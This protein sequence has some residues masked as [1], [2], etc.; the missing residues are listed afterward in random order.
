MSTRYKL[1]KDTMP[2]FLMA[3]VIK[4]VLILIAFLVQSNLLD[5]F[6]TRSPA[7][8]TLIDFAPEI[9]LSL[10]AF[11][12]GTLIIV[13]SIASEKTPKL[14]DLFVTEYWSRLFIWLIA[15]SSM[16]NIFLHLVHGRNTI[17]IDNFIFLNNYILLPSFVI[18]AIPYIFYILKFTKSSNVIK[19]IYHENIRA[20][21]QAAENLPEV[22]V[23]RNH[24]QLLET[25]NQLNDL[26]QY[27]EFKGPKGDIITRL[28]KSLRFYLDH[29]KRIPSSYFK[30]SD[31]I[32]NDISFRTLGE[33][34]LQIENERT[35]YEHKILRVLGTSYLLLIKESHYDL[36]SLCGNEL[37][38]S[39]RNAA[40]LDDQEVVN[41]IIIHFNTIL[42]FGINHGIKAR[43]IRNVYNTIFHY[44]QLIH[45]FIKKR[46]EERVVQC[47]RYFGFY[48]NEVG[49]LSL[50]EP[51]FLF[52]I[53]IFAIEM[54]KILMSL[55]INGLSREHQAIVLR[56][57]NDLSSEKRKRSFESQ[58]LLDS[59][60]RLIQIALCL[61]YMNQKEEKFL[62]ITVGAIIKDFGHLNEKQIIQILIQDLTGLKMNVRIFGRKPIREIG[63][64]TTH[65]TKF[66]Y[67]Y[68]VSMYL[69]K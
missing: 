21:S 49:K 3:I 50:S 4:V 7:D 16:E 65:H 23:N 60:L 52:L 42:R 64:F 35:F 22:E 39:A 47:C 29:K 48:A 8:Y 56:M 9:W 25:I 34:Y 15:L 55:N 32:K 58:W 44:S 14:I 38:A 28:G 5:Y 51:L 17:F 63:I 24:Y 37:Y 20:I 12:F 30:V 19:K 53:E 59:G 13:I 36:A 54:Q 1:N 33:K 26:L 10:L 61:F 27:I 68:L 57:F 66:F 18:V 62:E 46:E 69:R 6:E 40:D 31:A 67:Q 43:E 45:F 41:T 2:S 11:V